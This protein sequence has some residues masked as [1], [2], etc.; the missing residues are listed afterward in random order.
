MDLIKP[1]ILQVLSP[2]C[3]DE[4]FLNFNFFHGK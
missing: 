2:E 3:Y 4:F 1:A